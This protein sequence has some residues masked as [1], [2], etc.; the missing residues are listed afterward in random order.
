[1]D[2]FPNTIN[3]YDC[4]QSEAS[5]YRPISS[6]FQGLKIALTGVVQCLASVKV[7]APLLKYENLRIL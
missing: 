3:Q 1:M 7:R 4:N 5:Y 2:I 6:L